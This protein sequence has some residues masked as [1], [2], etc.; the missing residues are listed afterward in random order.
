M[1]IYLMYLNRYNYVE[2]LLVK[3]VEST[4]KLYAI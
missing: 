3:A 2:F 4:T 1:P